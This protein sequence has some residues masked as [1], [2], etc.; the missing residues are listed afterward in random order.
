MLYN[1]A[2]Y[3]VLSN[4]EWTFEFF[5]LN[6]VHYQISVRI[7]SNDEQV[8]RMNLSVCLILIVLYDVLSNNE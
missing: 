2:L 3:D 8:L 6:G 4:N 1:D 5:I 7:L